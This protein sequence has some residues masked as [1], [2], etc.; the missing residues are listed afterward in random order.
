MVDKV[1]LMVSQNFMADQSGVE[2]ETTLLFRSVMVRHIRDASPLY[3]FVTINITIY[4]P[5]LRKNDLDY[6]CQS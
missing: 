1:L 4:F 2:K 6:R 3:D 5:R